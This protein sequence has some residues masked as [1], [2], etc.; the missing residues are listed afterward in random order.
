[1]PWKPH[2]PGEVPTLGHIVLDWMGEYLATPDRQE[3]EPFC[4]TLEQ[5]QFIINY[6]AI[7][8]H[9]G[10]R[11]YRRGVISRPKGWG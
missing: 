6:Y 3:Y 5:A 4:P 9:T 2:E 1:M 8:P 7:N 11:R 10:R